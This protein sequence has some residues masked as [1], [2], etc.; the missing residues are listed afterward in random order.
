MYIL[1]IANATTHFNLSKWSFDIAAFFK[2]FGANVHI[3]QIL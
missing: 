1:L 3:S 2:N